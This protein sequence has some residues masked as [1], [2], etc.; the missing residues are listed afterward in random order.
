MGDGSGRPRATLCSMATQRHPNSRTRFARDFISVGSRAAAI[1]LRPFSGAL[2]AA[3]KGGIDLERRTLERLIESREL[4]WVLITALTNEHLQS[5][6]RRVLSG[7]GMRELVDSFFDSGLFEH[8]IDR[9]IASPALWRLVDDV[10]TSPRVAAAIS[11]QGLG[12]ADQLGDELR[13][14]SRRADVRI[15]RLGQRLVHRRKGEA[16]A[17]PVSDDDPSPPVTHRST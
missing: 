6:L 4:E 7:E 17:S 2:D 11:Q 16:P 13:S 10:A 12:F 1:T 9:L 8:F 15:E 14:R 3:A 5:T